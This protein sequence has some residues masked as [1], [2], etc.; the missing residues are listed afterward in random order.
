VRSWFYQPGAAI[1]GFLARVL[2]GARVT[3]VEHVPRAGAFILV[4]NHCSNLDPPIIGWATGHKVGRVI[5]FMAKD[6]MRRW[7][8]AGWLA[9]QSG[10]I[11]VRRGEADR[12]AQK[13]ALDA[14]AAGR[15]IALFLEGT[16]SRD[17]H[18]KEGRAGAA[19]LAMRSGAPLLPVAISGTHRI[20]PGRSRVPHP[21]RVAIRIGEPFALPHVPDGRLDRAALAEGTEQ[22][23]AAIESLLPE[24]QQRIR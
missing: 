1:C 2:F 6:E 13:A 19:F 17:G 11:F 5:H 7:P 23:M 14:L 4:C 16:R 22:I 24:E 20:F 8:V 9:Q 21:S 10:V 18:L 12:A 3:G 15:P